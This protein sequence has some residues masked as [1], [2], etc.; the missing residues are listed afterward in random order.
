MELRADP[1]VDAAWAI[2]MPGI[3]NS[4]LICG[5][6]SFLRLLIVFPFL[7]FLACLAYIQTGQFFRQAEAARHSNLWQ[8]S[9]S[10]PKIGQVG[11]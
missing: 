2:N 4:S 11:Y 5:A 9:L 3:A 1:N 6:E 10:Y 7:L 8:F